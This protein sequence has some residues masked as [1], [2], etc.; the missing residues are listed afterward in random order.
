YPAFD[1]AGRPV[2]AVRQE[3]PSGSA[4]TGLVHGVAGGPVGDLAIGRSGEGDGLIG[5]LQ[6]EPGRDQVVVD[7]IGAAPKEFRV[8][9]PARWVKPREAKIHWE[10]APSGVGGLRYAVLL[11]GHVVRKGLRKLEFRPRPA[12]LGSGA[13]P[14]RVL[15][16]DRLGQQLLSK[17]QRLRVDS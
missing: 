4:Q 1:S 11:G 6:G 10:R 7:E 3:A 14:V 9:V 5:F 8:T 17:P 2:V 15:A 16:T 12:L 13:R